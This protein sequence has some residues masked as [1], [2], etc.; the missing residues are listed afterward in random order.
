MRLAYCSCAL[1]A[2]C[3][4][5]LATQKSYNTC[6]Q[7]MIIMFNGSLLMCLF[8]IYMI[9]RYCRSHSFGTNTTWSGLAVS[10]FESHAFGM[11]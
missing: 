5:A 1:A 2:P 3:Q 11:Y 4:S 6:S 10:A 8:C 7:P 9:T